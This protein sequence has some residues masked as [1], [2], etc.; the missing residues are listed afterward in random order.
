M[1]AAK[2]PICAMLWREWPS[3]PI[4]G[5]DNSSHRVELYIQPLTRLY[6]SIGILQNMGRKWHRKHWAEF[7]TYIKFPRKSRSTWI[8]CRLGEEKVFQ[9]SWSVSTG[10][11]YQYYILHWRLSFWWYIIT[12]YY[13]DQTMEPS[14]VFNIN[15]NN[16]R[17]YYLLKIISNKS[18]RTI[19][20]V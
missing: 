8:S 16:D 15:N 2:Q 3:S 13:S 19:W 1:R 10:K 20:K 4:L 14:L 5:L 18:A 9:E 6:L 17:Y 11:I 7:P 12:C